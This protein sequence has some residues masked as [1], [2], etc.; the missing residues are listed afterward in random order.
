[1]SNNHSTKTFPQSFF[2]DGK[3]FKAV[4]SSALVCESTT[5]REACLMAKAMKLYYVQ[6][7]SDNK[8]LISFSVSESDLPWS[9]A[10]IIQDIRA[11]IRELNLI[12]SWIPRSANSVTHWVTSFISGWL[13][14]N[15]ISLIWARLYPISWFIILWNYPPFKRKEKK[16]LTNIILPSPRTQERKLI[17]S[18]LNT[19]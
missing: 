14:Q 11:F 12:V 10:C 2:Q 9:C 6:I 4:G 17:S 3:K 8:K 18:F 5:L 15:W 16:K 13:P 7:E 19:Q 1:M